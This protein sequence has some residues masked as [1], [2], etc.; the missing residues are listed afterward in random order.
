MDNS[1]LV[2]PFLYSKSGSIIINGAIGLL[3]EESED[4]VVKESDISHTDKGTFAENYWRT[5]DVSFYQEKLKETANEY[6]RRV[7]TARAKK[8]KL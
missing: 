7:W 3:T 1:K 4:F 8:A 5:R 2:Y 6:V